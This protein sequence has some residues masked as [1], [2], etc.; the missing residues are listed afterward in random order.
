LELDIKKEYME[1]LKGYLTPDETNHKIINDIFDSIN[2]KNYSN[3]LSLIDNFK[4]EKNKI[5][6]SW[7]CSRTE[8]KTTIQQ[9]E[10]CKNSLLY[11]QTLKSRAI[12]HNIPWETRPCLYEC[13]K[14]P[15]IDPI[16]FHDSIANNFW[17]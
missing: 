4:K 3:C 9:C 5:D 2:Q 16:T 8:K 17:K 13:G 14:N 6:I 1:N 12:S 10:L 11:R 7:V 15:D